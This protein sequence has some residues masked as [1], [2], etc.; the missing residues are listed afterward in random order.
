[1]LS[2]R[3]N[4]IVAVLATTMF[5]ACSKIPDHVRYI[6]KDA[7]AVAGINL[8]SLSKKIAWNMITGSKLFKEMQSRIPEKTT[9]DAM[10]GI[11]KAGIDAYNV[12]YVYVKTDTRFKGGNRIVGLVPL[13]DAG[14]W[15][16][17]IKQVFPK[18]EIKQHGDRKEASLGRDM[19]VGWNKKL[20]IMINVTSISADF[21]D[22][23]DESLANTRVNITSGN[24]KSD[25]SAEMDNAFG[26]TKENSIIGNPHFASL[27][28][29]GH[30]VDFWLNYGLLMNQYSGDVAE[31]MGGL[32]LSG[33]LWKDAALTAGFD[34]KKG[35][36]TGDMHYYVPDELKD[37]G[38]EFGAV[39]AD[40]DM[41][42]RLP[43]QNLGMVM[44]GHLSPKGL[45][46]LLEKTG[47]LG[48]ANVGLSTQ[49]MNIDN[50]LDAFTGDMAMVVNDF[51]L[52]AES[53]TDTFL[54]Q[55]VVHQNQK[56]SLSVSYV[57]K[58]NKKENFQ[59][60]V[61][62][63]KENG[64]KPTA[65]GFVIPINDKDSIYIAINDQYAVASNK[66]ANA[67]GFLAGDFKT[68]KM[69]E[70]ASATVV[71]HPGSAY[72]D[73]HQLFN[74]IDPGISHS[75]HDSA[76]IAESKKLLSNVGISGGEFKNDAFEYHLSI[77]FTNTEENSII[78]LMDYGMKIND[79]DKIKE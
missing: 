64:L 67:A 48:L 54:G 6:P 58:I 45:K 17:Y 57:V 69:P 79:A 65:N 14:Q 68:Q 76:M 32:S 9:K 61:K 15:E 10:A 43:D 63:A 18:V 8:K 31:K 26:V 11:E 46:G 16:S 5:A 36:I 50:I 13:A 51:S 12:F 49:G 53:V 20:L 33:A 22:D 74:N 19:Y 56:P 34:F 62:L 40:R 7:V 52:T 71:G 73:I 39:N 37:I 42:E 30:D 24:D 41:I 70:A 2:Y 55:P 3:R 23:D 29:E 25:M 59:T 44:A 38:K 21:G 66:Y 78:E 72:I 27:E 75:A 4:F 35:K 77:N 28:A 60:L 47:L 1:M